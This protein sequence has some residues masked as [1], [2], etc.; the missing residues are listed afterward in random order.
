MQNSIYMPK[1]KE[2]YETLTSWIETT[3][4]KIDSETRKKV[5]RDEQ[6]NF[7]DIIKKLA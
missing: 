4:A 2:Y 1:V 5:L 7:T 6:K 3:T